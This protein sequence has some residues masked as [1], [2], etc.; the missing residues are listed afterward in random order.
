MIIGQTIA[1]SSGIRFIDK[2]TL[3]Y[4]V[5]VTSQIVTVPDCID[6]DLILAHVMHRSPLLVTPV[7]WTLVDSDSGN[8]SGI[9]HYLSVYQKTCAGDT[10]D[11]TTWTQTLSGRMA[12]FITTY[13]KI[14]DVAAVI[15]Y[16]KTHLDGA[17]TS[18]Y[19]TAISTAD[20][21]GQMGVAYATYAFAG[22]DA[23]VTQMDFIITAGGGVQDTPVNVPM[24]RLCGGHVA[25]DNGEDTTGTVSTV[26]A[27]S[28]GAWV[29]I[30]LVIG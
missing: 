30:S 4:G 12:V 27:S 21:D 13:R 8:G 7:G 20:A 5:G 1:Q 23:L 10:G 28:D 6:D 11:A 26:N 29:A 2:S 14:G 19:A 17:S 24:N 9:D 25:L 15:D 16:D 22:S 3:V 18:P